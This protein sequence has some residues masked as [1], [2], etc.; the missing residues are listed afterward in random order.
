VNATRTAWVCC[1]LGA[2]EHYAVPRALHRS[3]RLTHLLTDAWVPTGPLKALGRLGQRHHGD[4]DGAPVTSLTGSLLLH[5]LLWRAQGR[6]DWDYFIARNQWFQART[7]AQLPASRDGERTFVFAHSYAAAGIFQEAKQ[8]QWTAVLG[9]IDPGPEHYAIQERL[10]SARP[11]Y[12]A[13]AAS[14]PA[15]YFDEWRQECELAEWIV[16]N[17]PWSRDALMRAG[18]PERKIRILPLP[19]EPPPGAPAFTRSYPEMFSAQRPL[20]ALFVGTASVTK[21]VPELLES[22]EQLEGLPIELRLVGDRAITVPDRFL[23]R[24]HIQWVGPVDRDTVMDYYRSSDVL[25]FPSHSDGYGM[26]QIEAQAW[27]LPIIASTHCGAVVRDGETGIVLEEI[28]SGALTA[29]L[30][31]LMKSPDLLARYSQNA[32]RVPGAT[33]ATLA[34]GLAAL[35][36]L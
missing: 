2:R 36:Q 15:R 34:E 26:A 28:S 11:E 6:R 9:Q 7:A 13:T 1:Q 18:V 24:P 30:R 10:V 29:S 17:S 22:L 3:G 32:R 25:V 16:V 12:R 23:A 27:A 19:Y 31:R 14:P 5:E 8:R 20:R 33:M 4:L 35:E 21:G